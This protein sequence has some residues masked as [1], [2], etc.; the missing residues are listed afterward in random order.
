MA[1]FHAGLCQMLGG[2]LQ[3]PYEGATIDVQTSADAIRR[4]KEWTT[5]VDVA[6]GSW[7]QVLF[8]GKSI[9]SFKPGEF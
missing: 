7:L 5:R 3:E 1:R 9:G 6:E 4:A 2:T 8:D